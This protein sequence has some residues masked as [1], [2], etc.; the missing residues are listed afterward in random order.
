MKLSLLHEACC[1]GDIAAP[2]GFESI[3]GGG[4]LPKE[5]GTNKKKIANDPAKTGGK[6]DWMHKYAGKIGPSPI[7]PSYTGPK[8]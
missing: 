6:N 5:V 2:T 7:L 4:G 3:K 1:T 8:G